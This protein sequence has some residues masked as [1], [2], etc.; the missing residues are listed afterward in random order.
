[1][2]C[3]YNSE[4][5]ILNKFDLSN[6]V[7][8]E[9]ILRNN[10]VKI[11]GTISEELKPSHEIYNEEFFSSRIKVLRLSNFSDDIPLTIS[12]RLAQ[13]SNIKIGDIVTLQG[14][15]RSYNNFTN[16]GSK[17]ILTVFVKEIEKLKSSFD[18]KSPNV[19]YLNGYV[20]KLPVYRVTPFGREIAD[21]L[22][23]VNRMYNKSDY[24]PCIAWG[25]NAKFVQNFTL[26]SNVKIWGRLQSR[27]Y[28]KKINENETEIRTAYEV[29]ISKIIFFKDQNS[30]KT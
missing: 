9:N 4:S 13:S 22:L 18:I 7:I 26:G 12:K 21:I 28:Q 17:L 14:Q 11:S 20:C 19:V 2:D 25:K 5:E 3:N 29:S 23:A 30:N 27:E 10:Y 1:V 16:V 6:I 8:D 15:F 24:I